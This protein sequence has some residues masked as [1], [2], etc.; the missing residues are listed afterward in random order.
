MKKSH[1]VMV[2]KTLEFEEIKAFMFYR[3]LSNLVQGEGVMRRRLNQ[4]K[5]IK[6]VEMQYW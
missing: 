4:K 1:D 2:T 6:S 5:N 3:Y